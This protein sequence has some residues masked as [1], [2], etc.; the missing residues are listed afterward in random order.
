[1]QKLGLSRYLNIQSVYARTNL[2]TTTIASQATNIHFPQMG[3]VELIMEL[4]AAYL[5]AVA[6]LLG[7]VV[8]MNCIVHMG[9]K[10][11]MANANQRNIPHQF[12]F[13]QYPLMAEVAGLQL[14]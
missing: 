5:I 2:Q 9:V 11:D 4:V 8:L 14:N 12:P 6:Q 1:M 10:K 13:T 7:S 3:T